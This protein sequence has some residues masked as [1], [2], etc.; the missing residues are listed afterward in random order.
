MEKV[1]TK[2]SALVMCFGL[3]A[4][5]QP[6][7]PS[8]SASHVSAATT[9]TTGT[10]TVAQTNTNTNSMS[11]GSIGGY[12]RSA[13]DENDKSKLSHALDKSPGKETH[14]VNQNS[15][16]SYTVVPTRAL[17]INGNAHC[18]KYS[19]TAINSGHT[20]KSLGT[21]CVDS[22]GSWKSAG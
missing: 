7:Q 4:C 3:A 2:L 14:W 12:L 10:K 20:E 11:G 1:L 9:M 6:S 8:Q 19:I 18:R 17:S 16:I 5:A 22:D 13:M 15:S 21:A